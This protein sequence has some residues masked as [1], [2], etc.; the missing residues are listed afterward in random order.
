MTLR[1]A[2]LDQAVTRMVEEYVA[3]NRAAAVLKESLDHAGVG[4]TPVVDH[5]TI[6]TLDIDRRAEEFVR[7]GYG[8]AETLDYEDWFAKVYRVAGY[9][10]LFVDQA[11][12]GDRGRT[13]IIPG[14]VAQFGDRVLHHVA[15]RVEDIEQ[16]IARLKAKGVVF[17]GTIVGE[18]GGQLRQIFTAPEQVDGKPFSVLEL[19]ERHRG[20][21]GFSPPQ[22]DSLM[23]S[24]TGT[25]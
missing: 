22:A 18:R 25:R 24:T 16:A 20:Y 19:T 1:G 5:I 9:P 15:V 21:Q 23:K 8:Y 11:Y 3:R 7:L 14:W 13:S 4:F 10:T 2:E 12:P 6:R 17:A